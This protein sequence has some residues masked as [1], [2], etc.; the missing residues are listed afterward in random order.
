VE[1]ALIWELY[2]FPICSGVQNQKIGN[3]HVQKKGGERENKCAKALREA[4][5]KWEKLIRSY[6]NKAISE[7]TLVLGQSGAKS[8]LGTEAA[9][10]R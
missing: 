5:E 9:G 7:L 4:G 8:K 1:G 10:K 3:S 2:E 6:E